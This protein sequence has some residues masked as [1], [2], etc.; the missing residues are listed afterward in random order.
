MA[1]QSYIGGSGGQPIFLGDGPT[2][3]YPVVSSG[4]AVSYWPGYNAPSAA[5]DLRT[6]SG[7]PPVRVPIA[8][9]VDRIAVLPPAP[10]QLPTLTPPPTPPVATPPAGPVVP[11]TPTVPPPSTPGTNGGVTNS[12]GVDPTVAALIGALSGGSGAGSAPGGIGG[13]AP[14]YPA[15]QVVPGSG[16]APPTS[17]HSLALIIIAVVIIAGGYYLY[18]KYRKKQKEDA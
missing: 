18:E 7:G 6:Y 1:V 5:V 17:G 13:G 3:S 8:S 4:G 14:V 10:I 12:A 2:P 16:T 9:P 11:T 15:A